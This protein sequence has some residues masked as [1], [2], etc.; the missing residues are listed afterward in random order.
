MVEH[1]VLSD[2]TSR[3]AIYKIHISLGKIVNALDTAAASAP[4]AGLTAGGG[5]RSMSRSA[6]VGMEDRTAIADRTAVLLNDEETIK[7]EDEGDETMGDAT[8]DGAGDDDEDTVVMHRGK[9]PT[10]REDDSLVDD[11]LTDDGEERAEF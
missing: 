10:R 7:E 3:N 2:A 5:R 1:P 8:V 9:T 6:S 11:L 4:G